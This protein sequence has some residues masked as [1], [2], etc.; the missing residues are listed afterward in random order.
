MKTL[1]G[2]MVLGGSVAATQA[3]TWDVTL[4]LNGF[5]GDDKVPVHNAA[6]Q[7][8]TVGIRY[9]DTSNTLTVNAPSGIFGRRPLSGDPPG[10]YLHLRAV[11]EDRPAVIGLASIQIPF[12]AHAGMFSGNLQ[13]SGAQASGLIAGKL[14]LMAFPDG[15]IQGPLTLVPEPEALALA[16]LG[17]GALMWMTRRHTA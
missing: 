4:E 16:I 7:G 6:I 3:T 14:H 1:I 5:H 15:E 10:S 8:G 2:V 13:F 11:G 9:D 12:S 17:L